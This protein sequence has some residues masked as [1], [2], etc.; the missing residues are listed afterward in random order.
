MSPPQRQSVARFRKLGIVHPLQL[1]EVLATA[2]E[3]LP[4]SEKE[5][6]GLSAADKFTVVLETARLNA[7]W[8]RC[9]Y[10]EWLRQRFQEIAAEHPLWSADG[11]RSLPHRMPRRSAAWPSPSGSGSCCVLVSSTL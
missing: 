10:Q 3:V 7:M 1:E 11:H 9:C 5:P 2:G 6:E 8:S 4:A